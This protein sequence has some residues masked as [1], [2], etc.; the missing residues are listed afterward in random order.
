MRTGKYEIDL[1]RLIGGGLLIGV[2]GVIVLAGAA[3]SGL[4]VAAAARS[5]LRNIDH[6]PSELARRNGKRLAQAGRAAVGAWQNG[7][8]Q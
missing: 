4:A 1:G 8:E 6:P 3:I 7:L 2:G 5:R